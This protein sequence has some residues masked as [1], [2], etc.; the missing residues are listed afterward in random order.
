MVTDDQ[1]ENDEGRHDLGGG[2]IPSPYLIRSDEALEIVG[3]P[4]DVQRRQGQPSEDPL[5]EQRAHFRA[6]IQFHQSHLQRCLDVFELVVAFGHVPWGRGDL[7]IQ[8]DKTKTEEGCHRAQ[9][10]G[11]TWQKKSFLMPA[12]HAEVGGFRCRLRIDRY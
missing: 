7:R 4:R 10:R 6:L 9:P 3:G 11:K 8:E 1:Q 5:R 12:G 2:M